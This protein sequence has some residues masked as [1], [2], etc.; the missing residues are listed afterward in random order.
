MAENQSIKI[1]AHHNIYN[2]SSNRGLRI[3]IS[4][5]DN[6]DEKTGIAILVPG[7]GGTID[8]N[9]YK[10]MRE[11]FADTHNLVIVQC[12]YFGSEFM[13]CASLFNPKGQL[14]ELLSFLSHE[15]RNSINKDFSNFL[16]LLSTKQIT[17][18]VIAQLGETLDHFN[19]MGF[20]QAIDIITAI[21]AVRI[22]L[23]ENDITFNSK[24][25]IG[26]GHS[27]G[28]YLLHLSNCLAPHLFSHIIDNSAWIEPGYLDL[29]RYL[30]QVYGNMELEVEFN[31]IA[32][33]YIED[34]KSLSLNTFY[35]YF[36]NAAKIISFQGNN[37]NLINHIEKEVLVSNIPHSEFILI[38]ENNVDGII[39]KSNQ[40]GLDA[41]FLNMFEYGLEKLGHHENSI[42]VRLIYEVVLSQ[43]K[44]KV[45]YSSMLPIFTINVLLKES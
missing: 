15:E 41:D 19:D 1:P 4:Y 32:K 14:E 25:V 26:Y 22:I 42:E 6:I 37:D 16:E 34:K 27:H 2:G 21:E 23:E 29:N 40:H 31:Y 12:D 13:Q 17:V 43:T 5:P 28:A 24:K 20:M 9:V 36:D 45:D 44:I 3:D 8:S 11:T 35:D 10:K 30:Y 18:P 33:E 38:D 7:F 39:F